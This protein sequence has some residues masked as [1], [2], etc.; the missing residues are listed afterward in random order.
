MTDTD[1]DAGTDYDCVYDYETSSVLSDTNSDEILTTFDELIERCEGLH[2]DIKVS[3]QTLERIKEQIESQD[4]I[5]INNKDF[6]MILN[7]FR[8]K[9]LVSIREN[10]ENIF[11]QLL[12]DIL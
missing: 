10:G 2:N 12:I 7:D 8:E 9:A 6:D 5:I 1:S 4:K 3:F 11:G